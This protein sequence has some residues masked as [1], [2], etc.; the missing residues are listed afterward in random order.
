MLYFYSMPKV[1]IY[2]GDC[3]LCD[4]SVSFWRSLIDHKIPARSY[5]DVSDQYAYIPIDVFKKSVVFIDSDNHVYTGFGAI[6][7]SLRSVFVYR[8]CDWLYQHSYLFQ[9]I[10]DR[11]YRFCASNRSVIYRCIVFFRGHKSESSSYGSALWIFKRGLAVSFFIALISLLTQVLGLFG[12]NGILPIKETA[13]LLSLFSFST[14]DAFILGMCWT[15]LI[16]SICLFLGFWEWGALVLLWLIYRTF[17]AHTYV[18]LWYQWD[19]LILELTLLTIISTKPFR[20]FS[21]SFRQNPRFLIRFA[22]KFLVFRLMT[23]SGVA[24][25]ISS[26]GSWSNLTALFYHFQTQPLPTMMSW[27]A[28]QSPSWLLH[29]GCLM[30]LVI[31]CV[32]PFFIFG[33]RR[34]RHGATLLLIGFQLLI[35]ATGNY[36]FFNLLTIVAL[37]MCL[38]DTWLGFF[39]SGQFRKPL[40][41]RYALVVYFMQT[42]VLVLFIGC[43]LFIDLNRVFP[44]SFKRFDFFR[45]RIQSTATI[46]SYG[47]F[48]NMTTVRRELLFYGSLD[49]AEWVPFPL[50]YKPNLPKQAPQFLWF[51]MPRLDWQLWFSSLEPYRP[52]AWINQ[53]ALRLLEGSST[54]GQLFLNSPLIHNQAPRHIMVTIQE[55]RFSS[56]AEKRQTNH[57][58]IRGNQYVY[59]PIISLN[60]VD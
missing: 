41:S 37:L 42:L 47:L 29:L 14:S 30:V 39:V 9:T 32:V 26:D 53:L 2:D 51:S 36:G 46:G 18:F 59:M 49:Q 8:W 50:K 12:S 40:M 54:V 33:P 4:Y 7:R 10:M 16:A 23:M 28:H 45:H 20:F 19:I 35:L 3:Q 34:F 44:D 22:Y 43:S 38:D 21:W 52:N 57:W 48:A 15:G 60:Q 6:F 11:L 13:S 25:L 1:L 58:W 27:F 55:Y 5:Q 24:K 31:E 17:V 56:F